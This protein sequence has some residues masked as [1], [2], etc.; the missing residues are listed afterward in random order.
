MAN[1]LFTTFL[2]TPQFRTGDA[3][4][5]HPETNQAIVEGVLWEGDVLMLL[6]SEKAGKSILGL[7]LAF[8]L[9]SGH[10]FLDKYAVTMP[11]SVLYIQTEGKPSEMVDRMLAM[12]DTLAIDDTRFYHLHQR[13]L[14]LDTEEIIIRLMQEIDKLPQPPKVIIVDSLY[15]SMLGDLNDNKSVRKLF[16]MLSS[17][18]DRYKATL[19]LIHHETKEARTDEGTLIERGDKGSYGSVFLRAWCSH[20]LYLKKHKDKSR[21]LTCDTQRSGKVLERED[22]V[23]VEPHPL[24]FELAGNISPYVHKVRAILEQAPKGGWLMEELLKQTDLS[25]TSIEKSLRQ[26]E[27]DSVLGKNLSKPRRY[28]LL[29]PK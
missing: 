2:K 28:W 13:F 5:T 23:L 14:P 3:L 22:L 18:L 10:P 17:L 29:R 1:P 15:T 19:I 9:T 4:W 20:I 11:C 6:G 7:Q 24:C 27:K 12:R 26:F 8:C 16:T 25:R 21:T